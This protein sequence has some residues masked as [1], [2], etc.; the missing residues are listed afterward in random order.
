MEPRVKKL[1]EDCPSERKKVSLQKREEF[2]GVK[3]LRKQNIL[4]AKSF[5]R[6]LHKSRVSFAQHSLTNF[7]CLLLKG[8]TQR[9]HD[10]GRGVHPS[11]GEHVD[12]GKQV[13]NAPG[14]QHQER[15]GALPGFRGCSGC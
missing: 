2:E 10:E 13:E 1:K 15:D 9:A 6:R 12:R 3:D 5:L 7:T 4:F 11:I 8:G 14:R